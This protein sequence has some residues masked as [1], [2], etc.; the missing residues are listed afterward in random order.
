N[1][2]MIVTAFAIISLLI[3]GEKWMGGEED[4]KFLYFLLPFVMINTMVP[5]RF[6]EKRDKRSIMLPVTAVSVGISRII[7]VIIPT[8]F[9]YLTLILLDTTLTYHVN[10]NIETY[11]LF[12]GIVLFIYSVFFIFYDIGYS[13][14]SKKFIA[15]AILFLVLALLLNITLFSGVIPESLTSGIFNF[16]DQIIHSERTGL[17][18]FIFVTLFLVIGSVFTYSRRK[19]YLE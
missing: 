14:I 5:M 12:F 13:F 1:K 15:I 4:T 2:W 7:F 6:K 16:I 17:S 19:S 8:A 3:L 11:M 18:W 9:L 10:L